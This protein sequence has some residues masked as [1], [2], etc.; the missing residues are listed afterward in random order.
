[1]YNT[2]YIPTFTVYMDV[3]QTVYIQW[4][5]VHNMVVVGF[6]FTYIYMYICVPQPSTETA[7]QNWHNSKIIKFIRNEGE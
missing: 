7:V 2:V 5:C 3:C 6:S 4:K 1:M